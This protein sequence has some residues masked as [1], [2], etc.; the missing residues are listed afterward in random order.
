MCGPCADG[1]HGRSERLLT[2]V[3]RPEEQYYEV[4]ENIYV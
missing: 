2:G 4:E 3:R 1:G